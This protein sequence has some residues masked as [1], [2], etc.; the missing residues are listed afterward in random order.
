MSPAVPECICLNALVQG[1]LL[2]EYVENNVIGF[3]GLLKWV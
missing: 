1:E 3:G 2:S